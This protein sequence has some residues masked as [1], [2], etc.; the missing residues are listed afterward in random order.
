MS[1]GDRL[2]ELTEE[3][4]AIRALMENRA[5]RDI[6]LP[7]LVK[8]RREAREGALAIE[9]EAAKRS[10][11]VQL[12]AAMVVVIGDEDGTRPGLLARR[13]D[14]LTRELERGAEDY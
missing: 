4:A 3:K 5:W 9:S 11:W 13:L 14:E 10:E 2:F 1:E 12:H 7:A 8:A 6:V